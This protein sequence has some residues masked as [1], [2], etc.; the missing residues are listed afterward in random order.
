MKTRLTKSAVRAAVVAA[1]RASF[2]T[3]EA[4]GYKPGK[5]GLGKGDWVQV[6]LAALGRPVYVRWTTWATWGSGEGWEIDGAL[7]VKDC[8]KI[9]RDWEQG[10]KSDLTR[11]V[12]LLVE[13]HEAT[14]SALTVGIP[15][16]TVSPRKRA[17]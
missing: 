9:I 12:D 16:D 3:S 10:P 13:R 6:E 15:L 4:R 11:V 5:Q 8:G 17:A 7:W 1:L 2:A 14:I